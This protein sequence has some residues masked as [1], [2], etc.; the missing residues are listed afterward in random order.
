MTTT[1]CPC[2]LGKA[3]AACC[4]PYIEGK[5]LPPTAEALMRSR[6]TSYTKGRIDYIE[7]THAPESAKDFDKKA[8]EKWAR[9][10]T[11]KGLQIVAIKDGQ[12]TDST[13]IVNFVA[14]FS[15]GSGDY[16]HHEI[17][18][19]RKDGT[20]W[21]FVDGQSPKPDTFVKTGPD[22]GRNDPCHCGSGKKFKKCHG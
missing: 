18:T 10:S 1:D 11:W 9:E 15:N 8:S 12:P 4:E 6:Y 14:F 21:L 22:V 3:Y 7:R 20:R 5:I 2:G 19:F 17:A 13:G 16:Q